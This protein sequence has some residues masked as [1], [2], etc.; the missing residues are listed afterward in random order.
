MSIL[1]IYENERINMDNLE[2]QISA[3]LNKQQS[4]QNINRDITKIEKQLKQLKLKLSVSKDSRNEIQKQIANLNKEKRQLYVDL[5]LRKDALKSEYKALQSQNKMSLNIDTANAVKN[6]NTTTNA[7][8]DTKNETLSLADGLKKAF[9]NTGI[10]ISMQTAL[11]LVRRAANDALDA[12]K[13]YDS[14]VTNLSVITGGSRESSNQ[15]LGDLAE[16]SLN[17][18]VDISDLEGAAETILRT[19]KSI[20]ETNKYLENT[21]YL[22]KLGFQDM[23][24]SASQLVTIGNAYG[25]TADEMAAVVDK[26]VKLDTSANTTAGLLAEG[27]AKSAQNAKLAGFNIDQ[28]SASIAGLKNVVNG[29]ESQVANSLNM[30]FSRLQN[31]KLGKY[32]I[33]TEDGSENITEALND[34]EKILNTVNIKLRDSKNEFRDISELFTELSANWSKFNSVQQSAIATTIAGARQRNTFIALI[35]NWNKIQELTDVSL[36]SMGTSVEKYSNY[37]QSIESKSAVLNTS[38]KELWNNL[39]PTEFIGNMTDAGTAVVQFTD[40]YQILQTAIKSAAFY[41]LAKG[42]IATKNSFA[43]MVTDVKNLSAAFSLA[44]KGSALTN[45]EFA[46]LKT[47]ASGLSDKQLKLLLSTNNLSTAQKMQLVNTEG[48]TQ[49]EIQAKYAMLGISQANQTTTASTFSLSGAF[50]SLWATIAANPVMTLTIAFTAVSTIITT[51]QQKQEEYRQS[52]KDTAKETKELTDNLNSLYASYSDMKTGVDNGTASKEDLTEATNK[53]LEALGYEVSAVDDLIAK[54]GDLHTAINQATADRLKES[55][56]DLANAVDVELDELTHKSNIQASM[57]FS[58]DKNDANKKITD[59]LNDFTSKNNTEFI[60]VTNKVY[61]E[62]SAPYATDIGKE[63]SFV[64]IFNNDLDNS[65]EGIKKRLDELNLLKQSLFDYFGAED[66]Q[67]VDLYKTVNNQIANLSASYDEY[68]TAL[69]DYNNTAAEA[70]IVQSLVGKEIPKTVEEY[71]KYRSELIKSANDS[72]EYI[73]SQED[74]INSIDGTLSKMNEFAD[75]QN[76]LNNI[77][78]A[79]DKFVVGKVN[80]KPI[81]DFIN[82]LSDD[83]LSIL[84]QLDTSVF[85]NGLEG[86]EQAIENFKNN[87]D[88]QI[89]VDVETSE[90]DTSSL[91]KLQEAYDDLSKSAENYTKSQKALTDALD[92]QKEHGQLSANTIQSLVDA[93]YAQALVIDKVTGAVTLNIKE[94]ERLNEQKRQAIILD[95]E[96]QKIELDQKFKDESKAITDLATEMQYANQ[97]RREAIALEMQQHGLTMADIQAQISALDALSASTTAP[98]FESSSSSGSSTKDNKPKSIIDFETELARRQHEIKMGRMEED[99]AYFDWLEKAYREAYKGLTGYQDDIYKYEEMVYDGRQKLAEDFYNEQKKKHE[100][101]VEELETQITVAE[102]K[103]VN[104]NGNSLNPAEKFDYIRASYSDLIAENERRINEIMQSGIEGHEDE[105]KELEKQIEEYADKLQDVFK[106]EIDYEIKY[107]EITRDKYNDFI[108]SRIDRYE[109]EKK[110][111]EDKY[112]TEIKSI[113]DTINALKDKNDETKTAIDLKKAEQDLENAKQRTRMVYGADGTVSYRQDTDKVEEAQ[114]KVDDLKLEMLLDSLE[115]QKEAKE[116]EKD[117]ALQTYETM[118]GDLE[119]QKKDRD[120]FFE[121]V[122]EKLDNINNPKPTEGIDRVIDKT[123]DNPSESNEVKQGLK[124]VENAVKDGTEQAK[125]NANEVKKADNN[126]SNSAN[127]ADN[128]SQ[129]ANSK[130]ATTANSNNNNAVKIDVKQSGNSVNT[131]T[132]ET[133]DNKTDASNKQVVVYGEQVAVYDNGGE[134]KQTEQ[135]SNMDSFMKLLYSMSG[136]EPDGYERWKRGEYDDGFKRMGNIFS[137]DAFMNRATKP[138]EDAINSF[139]ETIN[140]INAVNAANKQPVS[141]STGDIVIQ[142][143]VGDAKQLAKEVKNEIYKEAMMELPNAF[144]KQMYTNLK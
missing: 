50:K 124:D 75:V 39:L 57:S 55:L 46:S 120:E 17:F 119:Q 41:A 44:S 133:A 27:V 83:D 116:A 11:N 139:N 128:K 56:P 34:T 123:Y 105:V 38:M 143:P 43:G 54:Y 97:E 9:A 14:Y 59:F 69:S 80:S 121:V 24:T 81:L 30:I 16:K 118:I 71:K 15:L 13:Q 35:E 103:S 125:D 32:V 66:V 89:S 29:S 45:A 84:I 91:D 5:K 48:L 74:I 6:V 90:A 72:K 122:L 76:R 96:Q 86:A 138:Y 64:Q 132:S 117:A 10:M 33:E 106:D 58:I 140:K 51:V 25:Y 112:D 87:P 37:L 77:E 115:K 52:I 129:S 4:V 102:N 141:I 67:N 99:E 61:N 100:N 36:N 20:D 107:I 79:K 2:I 130:T 85:D 92:E 7:V 21:V 23:D 8:R 65:V 70:Q 114:Q 78:T 137:D 82:S 144:Q 22:S 109:D 131:N 73:G 18:K 101:R 111:I 3:G 12:I 136:K 40:K 110:A 31:V 62:Y 28:L 95:I 63:Y 68:T 60:K 94:Y 142:N 104:N 135:T 126:T 127:K 47:I 98:T 1:K 53:L 108:D 49:A 88:N 93:G 42:A 19:G 113:D 26:F 134:N